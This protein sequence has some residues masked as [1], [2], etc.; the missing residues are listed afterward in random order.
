MNPLRVLAAGFLWRWF[1]APGSA[2]TLLEAV[3]GDDEQ[4]RMLAGMSLV[5]A[6]D[7]SFD[8]I[9]DQIDTG[10]ATPPAVRLLP[11]IDPGR[12]RGVLEKVSESD[13]DLVDTATECIDTINR[14]EAVEDS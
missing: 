6:G 13:G 14:M 10:Q 12:A 1:G 8:L 3:A 11:D 9:E 5:K 4:N 2:D 7:R